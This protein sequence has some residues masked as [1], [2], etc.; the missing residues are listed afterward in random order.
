M[1]F[2]HK[3]ALG[4]RLLTQP[5]YWWPYLAALS[6]LFSIFPCWLK[7]FKDKSVSDKEIFQKFI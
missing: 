5:R 7:E 1:L 6:K 3:M 4:K 2:E